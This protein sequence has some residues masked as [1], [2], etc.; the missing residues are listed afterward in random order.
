VKEWRIRKASDLW[1]VM[2][3]APEKTLPSIFLEVIRSPL[4]LDE[5]IAQ[6][7]VRA[8][9][10]DL[11]WRDVPL[12][13]AVFSLPVR[14]P[15]PPLDAQQPTVPEDAPATAPITLENPP[16]DIEVRDDANQPYAARIA[17]AWRIR[18]RAGLQSPTKQA[19]AGEIRNIL[20][21]APGRRPP[22]HEDTIAKNHL[23]D[24]RRPAGSARSRNVI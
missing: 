16:A 3:L 17:A 14:P 13:R 12:L 1:I 23:R 9:L 6:D 18:M 22:P 10:R 11:E 20:I 2:A 15:R 19:E 21:A 7:M 4:V 24:Y 5:G 8:A